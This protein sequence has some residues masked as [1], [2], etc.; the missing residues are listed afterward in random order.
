MAEADISTLGALTAP[1]SAASFLR[2]Y[3][4]DKI[5]FAHGDP[6]RLPAFLR[7]PELESVESLSRVYRGN[8]R[9]TSGR[10]YQ[11][12]LAIDQVHAAS[13]Y[14]MGLTVQ[15]E[16]I[17]PFVAATA[18]DL[19][20][21][22]SELGVA[23]G[24]MRASVFS[25][26]QTDGLSVHFDAQDLFSIQLKGTKRFRV[27]PVRELRYP[28][29]TQFVPD[30][31]PFDLLYPQVTGGFPDP[32]TVEFIS[33]E[34]Q[35]GSVLFL[36]RGTWHATESGG[37]SLSVSI[38]LYLPSAADCV[39]E[40]LQLLLLQHPEWRRPLYGGW[41]QGA[42]REAA[43]AQLARLLARLPQDCASLRTEDVLSGLISPDQRLAA[44]GPESRF[45]K[46]PHSRLET[47]PGSGARGY[48]YEV[49]VIKI[50]DAN[51]GERATMRLEVAPQ[52][53]EVFRWIGQTRAA[54]AA[55]ELVERFPIFPFEQH[56]QI[57]EAAVRAGL[58]RLLWF[59]VSSQP[60]SDR[61]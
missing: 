21:L 57:L 31:E 23:R 61:P 2:D 15:F 19:R 45:Q 52:A 28:Y 27:A 36:P 26:P 9:F 30:N 38:G 33:V 8:L 25:S 13:L 34:M 39:L 49:V 20:Q 18:S 43:Q 6:A 58:I 37:D 16:D 56:R 29:G 4:P 10:R 5:F 41:G 47:D 59:P 22:E 54:F 48:G 35:P 11:K 12:M 24:S 60:A 7:A 50:A 46:T 40:Q 1:H 3:W 51:Y 44:V 17:A 14:R 55:R 42:A 32:A 53:A